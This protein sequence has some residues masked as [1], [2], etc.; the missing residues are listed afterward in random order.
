MQY[1]EI[2]AH[3]R[4]NANYTTAYNA[5]PIFSAQPIVNGSWLLISPNYRISSIMHSQNI[6]PIF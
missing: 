3:W 6:L 2:L 5:N 1:F 4:G